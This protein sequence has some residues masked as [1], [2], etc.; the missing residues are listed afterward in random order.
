MGNLNSK[1]RKVCS[2][3]RS[4]V[5]L[6]GMVLATYNRLEA[7]EE[8]NWGVGVGMSEGVETMLLILGQYCYEAFYVHKS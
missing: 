4:E 2:L 7:L 8:I 5:F 3:R 6:L 1:I